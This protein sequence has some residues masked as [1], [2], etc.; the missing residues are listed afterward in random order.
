MVNGKRRRLTLKK[1]K[2]EDGNWIE[3]DDDIADEAI[4][5]FQKQFTRE[6]HLV[7]LSLLQLIP[8]VIDEDD[9]EKMTAPPWKK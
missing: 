2:K 9:N 7:D 1:M 4:I 6:E 8:R 5:F 3:G